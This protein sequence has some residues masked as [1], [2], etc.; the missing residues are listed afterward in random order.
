[1][2]E[3]A[4]AVGVRGDLVIDG[5]SEGKSFATCLSG[6]AGLRAVAHGV[7]EV[8][9]LKAKGFAFGDV[10]LGEGE[11]GGGVVG[12]CGGVWGGGVRGGCRRESN[13]C[14]E[15][16]CAR[17]LD[18]GGDDGW[19]DADGEEFLAGEVEA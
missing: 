12:G 6:N 15:R 3:K 13:A 10:G 4:G 18:G 16:R 11:A 14:S 8:F 17:G 2:L 5:E 7:E 19:I 1:M 9:K